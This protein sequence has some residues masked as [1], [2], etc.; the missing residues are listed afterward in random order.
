MSL[1]IIFLGAAAIATIGTTASAA[2]AV[3]ILG[4]GTT[5]AASR[6]YA[7]T[8]PIRAASAGTVR[9]ATSGARSS[10]LS[11][12]RMSSFG[13]A[14]RGKGQA[15]GNP[16]IPIGGG[17]NNNYAGPDYSTDINAL[18][19]RVESIQNQIDNLQTGN[20]G[21][22]LCD[23]SGNGMYLIETSNGSEDCVPVQLSGGAFNPPQI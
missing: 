8:T 16:I 10:S 5:S 2:P 17:T 6:P 4:S 20:S 13:T 11:S 12:A 18:N 22:A 23:S 1:K 7:P 3:R 14:I 21:G 9:A 19:S 15:S